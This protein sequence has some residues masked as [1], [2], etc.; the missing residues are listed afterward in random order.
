MDPHNYR[1]LTRGVKSI[2]TRVANE[3]VIIRFLEENILS[4]FGFPRNNITGNA[5]A[6]H[7]TKFINLCWDY[8]IELVHSTLYYP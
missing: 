2:L 8:N 3:I 4:R 7:S 6:F 5:Q 1:L